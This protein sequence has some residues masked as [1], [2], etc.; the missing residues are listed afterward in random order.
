M[1]HSG[2]LFRTM[3]SSYCTETIEL[4][5]G[6]LGMKRSV[7]STRRGW[8]AFGPNTMA[9]GGVKRSQSVEDT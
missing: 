6:V 2:H 1:F 3:A 7:Q 9:L 5:A 4:E 8:G